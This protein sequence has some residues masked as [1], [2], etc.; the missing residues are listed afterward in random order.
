MA[1]NVSTLPRLENKYDKKEIAAILREQLK[2]HYPNCKFSITTERNSINVS[3]MEADFEVFAKNHEDT[4]DGYIQINYRYAD[5]DSRITEKTKQLV[6]DVYTIQSHYNWDNSDIMTDYFDVNFYFHFE[7]GKWNRPFKLVQKANKKAQNIAPVITDS[8]T[9]GEFTIYPY[10]DTRIAVSGNTK[11]I[12][13]EFKK[14]T[15]WWWAGKDKV[16]TFPNSR[17]PE[18]ILLLQ[19]VQNLP[20]NNPQDEI[21]SEA[22][23]H[24]QTFEKIQSGEIKTP[25]DLGAA[26]VEDHEKEQNGLFPYEQTVE[27]VKKS[28]SK[29]FD[30]YLQDILTSW[31]FLIKPNEKITAGELA[32]RIKKGYQL[33]LKTKLDYSVLMHMQD[34]ILFEDYGYGRKIIEKFKKTTDILSDQPKTFYPSWLFIGA[35]PTGD[36]YADNRYEKNG[37]YRQIA[38]VFNDPY[39]NRE[40]QS[41]RVKV[42]DDSLPEYKELI[43]KLQQKYD[44]NSLPGQPVQKYKNGDHVEL[45]ANYMT[46]AKGSKGIITD[47]EL[48]DDRYYYRVVFGKNMSGQTIRNFIPENYL[49]KSDVL[50][51][52]DEWKQVVEPVKIISEEI[53]YPTQ[54]DDDLND[55]DPDYDIEKAKKY[56]N[57]ILNNKA[58]MDKLFNEQ[59]S[60]TSWNFRDGNPFVLSVFSN[61]HKTDIGEIDL[62][63]NLHIGNYSPNKLNFLEQI[64][65]LILS[66]PLQDENIQTKPDISASYTNDFSRNKAIEQ[67]L[68]YNLANGL[69]FTQNEKDFINTY[70][71]YGG[72]QKYGATGKGIMTEY[73]TPDPTVQKMW[74]LAYEHG[75]EDGDNVLENSVGVGRFLKYVPA[76]SKIDAFEINRYS[77]LICKILYP[78]IDIRNIPFEKYFVNDQNISIKGNV[79]PKYHLVIGNPPYGDFESEYSH[80]E[81][82]YTKAQNLT[83]YF[84]TRSLDLLVSGGLLIYIIGVSIE[85]GGIPFLDSGRTETKVEIDQKADLIDFYRLGNKVFKH[86]EVLADIVVFRKK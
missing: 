9:I 56:K 8:E 77:Y 70:S 63:R 74:E 14:I 37:E 53:S 3:L 46:I 32:K 86:T 35:Y 68:E 57:A 60:G 24:T 22:E 17:K 33:H 43:K 15:G 21:K 65:K 49:I 5:N 47:Y 71:G 10:S 34:D 36:L 69:E 18:V 41:V 79:T 31:G 51:P 81:K 67:L 11:P 26:I 44:S 76:K 38:I 62:A 59:Y 66:F 75:F 25:E 19:K 82:K 73:F 6:N 45:D 40:N 85:N 78:G 55:I 84:I 2:K 72:L 4:K 16:W 64:K 23:A 30:H 20:E 42:Y 28:P 80:T 7:I 58:Q 54:T 52:S 61:L 48:R 50:M 83:E 39:N 1:V 12:K 27:L 13:D 29:N